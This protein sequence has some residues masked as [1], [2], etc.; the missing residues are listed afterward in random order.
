MRGSEIHE[1]HILVCV[2]VTQSCPTLCDPMDYSL[3]DSSVHC[4]EYWS[5]L[6]FLFPGDLP[7]PGIKPGSLAFWADSLPSEPT[8]KLPHIL[9]S[10]FNLKGFLSCHLNHSW[11]LNERSQLKHLSH[12]FFNYLCLK[13]IY[14]FENLRKASNEK[15]FHFWNLANPGSFVHIFFSFSLSSHILSSALRRSKM[16]DLSNFLPPPNM[17]I[18]SSSFKTFYSFF[19]LIPPETR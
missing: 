13:T 4:I 7:N 2:W 18:L 8:G 6:P 1:P 5:G 17:E 12:P 15:W 19:F 11:S 9:H 16:T 14:R 10:F 3:P